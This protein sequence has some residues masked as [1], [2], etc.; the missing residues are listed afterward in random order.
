MPS[1]PS[2]SASKSSSPFVFD[3]G[4]FPTIPY[5]RT[6]MLLCMPKRSLNREALEKVLK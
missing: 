2:A 4:N 6:H 1:A 5:L 3:I